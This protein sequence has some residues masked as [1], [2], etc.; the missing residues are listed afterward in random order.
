MFEEVVD[1]NIGWGV[2]LNAKSIANGMIK[3][4]ED[5]MKDRTNYITS[6]KEYVINN[7]NWKVIAE[8]SILSFKSLK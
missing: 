5:Y 7:Y 4:A 1:N 2:Q 6:C 8:K 3:A